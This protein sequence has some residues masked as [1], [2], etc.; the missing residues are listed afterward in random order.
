[1]LAVP[2][3]SHGI[4]RALGPAFSPVIPPGPP[5]NIN[6]ISLQTTQDPGECWTRATLALLSQA[7]SNERTLHAL[8]GKPIIDIGC[9]EASEAVAKFFG[10]QATGYIGIDPFQRSRVVRSPHGIPAFLLGGVDGLAY[11]RALP[12]GVCNVTVNALDRIIIDNEAYHTELAVELLRVCAPGGAVF[13]FGSSCFHVLGKAAGDPDSKIGTL[14]R[15]FEIVTHQEVASDDC[16]S[17]FLIR[18]S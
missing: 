9:G 14:L 12:S 13:G 4:V 18:S 3:I 2:D 7:F 16:A 8:V 1:M 17:M 5:T 11:L 10:R 6:C 15:G